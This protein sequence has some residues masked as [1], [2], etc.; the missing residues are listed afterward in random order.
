[1]TEPPFALV[2]E[3]T[4]RCPLHCV[5]CSNP[6][7]LA[8]TELD[9]AT[10]LDVVEQATELGVVQ[11]QLTG[12]EPLLR[13]DAEQLIT[14]AVEL[15]LYT[16]MVT[17]GIGLHRQRVATLAGAGLH[18]LQL[19]VQADEPALADRIAGRKAHTAKLQAL[20][21]LAGTNIV[22]GLNVVIHALNIDRL[23]SIVEFCAGFSPQRIEL[24]N[25]QYYGWALLNRAALLPTREQ[26]ARAEATYDALRARLSPEL[27]LV[28]VLP[29]YYQ[30]HPKPCMGGWA[31][32]SITVTPDG[33]A[34]PCL[35]A[36]AIT[37]LRFESVRNRPLGAIWHDSQA[38]N[39]FRGT[40]WMREP[41]RSCDRRELDHGGCR[42]QAF[43]LTGD[44][45]RTDPVCEL[46]PDHRLIEAALDETTE[47][48]LIHRRF[49]SAT[50]RSNRFPSNRDVP[51][52][53][54]GRPPIGSSQTRRR[55][56]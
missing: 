31:R 26:L 22:L 38:F 50:S 41:C 37:T 3:L 30:R 35:A 1:M 13:A 33:T 15:G 5:Y 42:C 54:D 12:G 24:A 34:L 56:P 9:T 52:S 44:A 40:G 48:R 7:E 10:W 39:A 23:A 53:R 8:V 4:H 21:E 14:R 16:H 43:L 29:D 6:A 36:T 49:P 2:A 45:R 11:L 27:E 55:P 32:T 25:A 51:R 46:S 20:Q 19:S 17:S 47:L 18:S 28:W